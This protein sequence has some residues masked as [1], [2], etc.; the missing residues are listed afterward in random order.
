MKD[1]FSCVIMLL[2]LYLIFSMC[3]F[4]AFA[5][6]DNNKPSPIHITHQLL[7]DALRETRPSV[8]ASERQRYDRMQVTFIY[9]SDA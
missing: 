6:G 1:P 8:T 5:I 7:V 2:I 4:Y 9:L 3:L